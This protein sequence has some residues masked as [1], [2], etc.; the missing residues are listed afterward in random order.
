MA[1]FICTWNPGLWEW[2]PHEF[3]AEVAATARGETVAANW[4]MGSRRYGVEAGDRVFLLRQH[5]DRGIVASG[6]FTSE[7]FWAEHWDGSGRLITYADMEWDTVVDPADRLPVEALIENVPEVYWQRIQGSGVMVPEPADDDLE[8]LWA[9]HLRA[10]RSRRKPRKRQQRSTA[11][12][13]GR[14]D[15]PSRPSGRPGRNRR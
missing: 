7:I 3:Q 6:T 8:S 4:S 14:T 9:D 13:S 1:T 12:G 5:S 11:P 2:D 10:L 15:A